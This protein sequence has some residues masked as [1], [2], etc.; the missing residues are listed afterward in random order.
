MA[1]RLY[2]ISAF[3][4]NVVSMNDFFVIYFSSILVV[5]VGKINVL[6]TKVLRNLS[7][8]LLYSLDPL[9]MTWPNWLQVQVHQKSNFCSI[10]SLRLLPYIQHP[11]IPLELSSSSLPH[12]L[13]PCS[14]ATV[15]PLLLF[16][17]KET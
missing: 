9:S 5:L 11:S 2:S 6:S 3:I 13:S 8:T 10:F 12:T 14:T 16:L 17:Y 15:I 1:Q 7:K 4:F